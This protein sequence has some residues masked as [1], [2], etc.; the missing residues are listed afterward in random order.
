MARHSTMDRLMDHGTHPPAD[1]HRAP[2]HDSEAGGHAAQDKHAGHDP[3][4]FRRQ[5]W[6]VLALTI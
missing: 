5:F 4:A 2:L 6:I 3:E 1:A